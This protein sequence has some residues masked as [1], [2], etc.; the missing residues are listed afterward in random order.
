MAYI[1]VAVLISS[2][3]NL[4]VARATSGVEL[5]DGCECRGKACEGKRSWSVSVLVRHLGVYLQTLS[6][7]CKTA[8]NTATFRSSAPLIASLTFSVKTSNSFLFPQHLCW[9]RC[10]STLSFNNYLPP[11]DAEIK[12]AWSYTSIP[13]YICM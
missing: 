3:I 11:F 5:R 13:T 4:S 8:R 1:L 10:P 7:L 12:N 9:F 2:Y 6:N